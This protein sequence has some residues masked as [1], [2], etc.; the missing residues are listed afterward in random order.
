MEEE[1]TIPQ[2]KTMYHHQGKG[3]GFTKGEIFILVSKK[4]RDWWAVR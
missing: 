2:V 1:V 4:N 3:M